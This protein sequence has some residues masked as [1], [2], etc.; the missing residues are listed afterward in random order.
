LL[1][2]LLLLSLSLARVVGLSNRTGGR[3]EAIRKDGLR[4]KDLKGYGRMESAV[5]WGAYV[6]IGG[7]WREQGKV[8]GMRSCAVAHTPNPSTSTE[9]SLCW[10][11]WSIPAEGDGEAG[12]ASPIND[13][14][15][16][17]QGVVSW[18]DRVVS[19]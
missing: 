12:P 7:C 8:M 10:V 4:V 16:R 17:R 19:C 15:S 2:L 1:P 14:C 9:T 6:H 11:P 3:R 13:M 18:C 5:L